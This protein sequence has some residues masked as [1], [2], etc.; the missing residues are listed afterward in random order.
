MENALKVAFD[1]KSRH[2]EALGRS[3]PGTR[4]LHL[5]GAFHG[6]SGYTM[7]LTNTDPNKVARFP[8]FDWPRI[9]AP[10][11][12]PGAD[13]VALAPLLCAGLIGFRS[14]RMAGPVQR[15]GLYGFGAASYGRPEPHS[16]PTRTTSPASSQS[17]SRV[18]A[19]TGTCVP[20]SS[21]R[22]ENCATSSTR[23]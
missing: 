5:R 11:V 22:C 15:L 2:N 20:S 4:V 7:S 23:C 6:R 17:R 1:W 21:R 13:P 16:R 12:R 9:D 10:Y 14:Y 3:A 18:R 8:K 19:A